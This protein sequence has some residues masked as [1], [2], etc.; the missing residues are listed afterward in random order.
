MS[1]KS[2]FKKEPVS[3]VAKKSVKKQRM[4]KSVIRWDIDNLTNNINTLIADLEEADGIYDELS[5]VYN[6]SNWDE[7]ESSKFDDLTKALNSVNEKIIEALFYVE[8]YSAYMQILLTRL[9]S[10]VN[11][12]KSPS[13]S[14]SYT[15]KGHEG[16]FKAIAKCGEYSL[17]QSVR[18]GN[19]AYN[20]ILKGNK[21]FA[22]RV[23]GIN[24]IRWKNITKSRE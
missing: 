5:E 6:D 13:L 21:I 22:D 10:N 7:K 15:I 9:Y 12:S 1:N 23:N 19:K 14:K 17:M 2:S 18:H 8:D 24:D 3:K 4:K 16:T 11:K 20:V